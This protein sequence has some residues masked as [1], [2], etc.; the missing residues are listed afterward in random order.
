MACI[1][2]SWQQAARN[3]QEQQWHEDF[4]P[5][6]LCTPWLTLHADAFFSFFWREHCNK[7]PAANEYRRC[8]LDSR[9]AFRA[10]RHA[11]ALD[12]ETAS[13]SAWT[14]ERVRPRCRR[15]SSFLPRQLQ[16]DY[17][18]HLAKNFVDMCDNFKLTR[19]L[20]TSTALL[21]FYPVVFTY[22][23]YFPPPPLLVF[24]DS[25]GSVLYR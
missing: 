21:P 5:T 20:P 9:A 18:L 4:R 19:T 22:D 1:Y 17:L 13:A 25:C 8:R 11:R 16:Q 12:P 7:A 24:I 3:S 23:I 14:C 10:R 15:L 2:F 6:S